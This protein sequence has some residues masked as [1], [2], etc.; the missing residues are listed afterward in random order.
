MGDLVVKT[1]DVVPIEGVIGG[2]VPKLGSPHGY[3]IT[4]V[5]SSAYA[6]TRNW[7]LAEE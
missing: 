7:N 5:F 1:H 3:L 4:G 2:H 6:N